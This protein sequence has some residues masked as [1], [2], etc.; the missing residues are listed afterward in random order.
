MAQ[1]IK[2][3]KEWIIII[4]ASDLKNDSNAMFVFRMSL[5]IL[6][7]YISFQTNKGVNFESLAKVRP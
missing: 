4:K 7:S 2:G 5:K 1:E 6:L 3:V